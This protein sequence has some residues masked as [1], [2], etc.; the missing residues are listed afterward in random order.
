MTPPEIQDRRFA[1]LREGETVRLTRVIAE[2][3]V[4]AFRELSGDRN[5]LHADASYA[6][7][8]GFRG[9]VAYGVLALAPVSQLAGHLLPGRRCLLL[10]LSA[11]FVAPVYAGDR[12]TYS[13]RL[14][15]RSEGLKVVT[16][17]WEACNQSDEPVLRGQYR[18]S[19]REEA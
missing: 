16:V 3:D 9:P 8:L 15:R 5:P 1:D 19:V 4:A 14:E 6:R 7:G 17:R 10:S 11:D 18:A 2:E 12:L 13:A